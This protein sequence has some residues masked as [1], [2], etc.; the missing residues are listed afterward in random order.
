MNDVYEVHSTITFPGSQV[1]DFAVNLRRTKTQQVTDK[2][3]KHNGAY[4]MLESVGINSSYN[5]LDQVES[6]M[7]SNAIYY[8]EVQ[9]WNLA[10]QPA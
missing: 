1:S 4:S 8:F 3:I 5:S 7:D 9:T 2:A 6:Q 10:L